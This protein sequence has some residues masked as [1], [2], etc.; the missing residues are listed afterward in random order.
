MSRPHVVLVNATHAKSGGARVH[1]LE[2]LPRLAR[3]GD[4]DVRYVVLA[5]QDQL[6]D[7]RAAGVEP[8]LVAAPRHLS[9]R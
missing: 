9:C 6:A 3:M 7:L 5:R 1:L 8:R 4:P 2:V